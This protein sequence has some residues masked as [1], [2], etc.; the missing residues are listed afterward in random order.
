MV[1]NTKEVNIVEAT[2]DHAKFLAWVALTASRSHMPRSMWDM[3]VGGSEEECLR[4]L[5]ALALTDQPHWSHYSMFIIAEIDGRPGSALGGYTEVEMGTPFLM[6]AIPEASRAVG[7]TEEDNVAGWQRAGTIALVVPEHVEGAWIVEN[8]ATLPEFRRQGLVDRLLVEILDRG[9]K[10]GA[11]TADV[12]VFIGND[13]AQAAYE[14]AGFEVI[15]E[16]LHPDF[17]AVYQ[18]PGVRTL[19]REV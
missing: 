6:Q 12:S 10:R 18:C 19:R 17:E 3:L 8:V 14:K 2:R 15:A 9:R 16:K 4:F 7:R 5:E 13:G 11:T 1:V